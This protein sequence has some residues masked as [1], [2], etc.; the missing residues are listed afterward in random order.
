[1]AD[2]GV[3][4]ETY[5]A[6]A[7][8]RDWRAFGATLADDV[9]YEL[10]QTRER[11][12]GRD[13]VVR[14]NAEHVG[15]WSLEI[16]RVVA[17]GAQAVSWVRFSVDEEETQAISFFTAAPDGRIQTITDFWPAPYEPPRERDHLVERF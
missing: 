5:W 4:V 11:V 16:E 2:I 7:Q 13:G 3:T 6:T 8:A 14:F 15:E 1:M 12:L 10:P 9:R 17:D